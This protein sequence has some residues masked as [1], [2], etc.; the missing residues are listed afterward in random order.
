M[1]CHAMQQPQCMLPECNGEQGQIIVVADGRGEGRQG[2][3]DHG[4]AHSTLSPFGL[5]AI[6]VNV[7]AVQLAVDADFM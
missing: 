3:N 6:G 4:E 1:L 5:H 2:P 7:P